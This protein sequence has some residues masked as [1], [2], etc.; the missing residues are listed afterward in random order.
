MLYSRSFS[1]APSLGTTELEN[2][3]SILVQT[4]YPG[5]LIDSRISEKLLRFPQ[6]TKE[7]SKKCPVYLKLPWIGENSLKFKKKKIIY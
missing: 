5:F 3:R 6:S 2:I 7:G 1:A 4:G